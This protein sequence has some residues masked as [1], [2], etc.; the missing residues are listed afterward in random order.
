MDIS[1]IVFTFATSQLQDKVRFYQKKWVETLISRVDFKKKNY[2]CSV[3]ATEGMSH[4]QGLCQGRTRTL[5]KN[6]EKSFAI[7]EAFDS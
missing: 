4:L 2:L 1:Q 3:E 5:N 6:Q 7:A